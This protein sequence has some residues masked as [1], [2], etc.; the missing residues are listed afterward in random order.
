MFDKS[1][2]YHAYNMATQTVPKT[3]Q[4]VM[5]YD[6]AIRF[7]RQAGEAIEQ[8]DFAERFRL[9]VKVSDI[10]TSLQ[11]ALDFEN[12][13]EVAQILYDYYSS[14]EARVHYVHRKNDQRI[15]TSVITELKQMRDAW[16]N[17]DTQQLENDLTPVAQ[18]SVISQSYDVKDYDLPA[19]AAPKVDTTK[20]LFVSA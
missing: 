14:I 17:I 8:N 19:Q 10:V 1:T 20:P 15:L 16:N 7:A 11:A 3:R 9:L 2:Q 18:D 12:G 13:G 6:G 5:L 4:I